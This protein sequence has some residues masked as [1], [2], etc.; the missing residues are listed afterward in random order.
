M[1]AV[2]VIELVRYVCLSVIQNGAGS[3]KKSEISLKMKI[4]IPGGASTL[5]CFNFFGL[6]DHVSRLIYFFLTLY[7]VDFGW[8]LVFNQVMHHN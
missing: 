7:S 6:I 5:R 2:D 1:S 3:L 8:F 4:L